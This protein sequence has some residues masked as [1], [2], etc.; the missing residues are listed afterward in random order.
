[1]PVAGVWLASA[2]VNPANVDVAVESILAEFER[3]GSE[4][5]PDA[6]L[7]D[8]QAYL[9]GVVPLTLETNEGV[10]STLLQME[11]HGLG[12]DYLQRYNDIVYGVTAEDVQRVAATYLRSEACLAVVAGPAVEQES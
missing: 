8:S 3:L 1:M 6:E 11:W 10:A 5:V 12:L 7:A 4:R 2:G 9:T